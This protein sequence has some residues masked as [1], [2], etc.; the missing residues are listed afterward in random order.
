MIQTRLSKNCYCVCG[1]APVKG[2]I[3]S[4]TILSDCLETQVVK[5]WWPQNEQLMVTV[6]GC[7]GAKFS[8]N[9]ANYVMIVLCEDPRRSIGCMYLQIIPGREVFWFIRKVH[10]INSDNVMMSCTI[11]WP[12]TIVNVRGQQFQVISS[13]RLLVW[14]CSPVSSLVFI[15]DGSNQLDKCKNLGN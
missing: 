2:C 5:Q 13:F 3:H 10:K 9:N 12:S 11:F 1:G 4:H 14:H 8:D 15:K 7:H 6:T